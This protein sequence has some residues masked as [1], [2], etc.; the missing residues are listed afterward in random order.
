MIRKYK[1]TVLLLTSALVLQAQ[2]VEGDL[3]KGND[4]YRI[5]Q[6]DLAERHYRAAL[7]L[8]PANTTARYNL[9][10]ALYHQRKFSEAVTVLDENAK[11]PTAGPQV[12]S[13]S[14][15]NKG[16]VYTKQKDLENSIEAYKGALR[17]DPD[18]RQARENLQKALLE[19]KQQQQQQKKNQQERER[20]RSNMSQKEAERQ[21]ERLQQKEQKAQERLQGRGQQGN[22]MPKDW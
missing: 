1:I 7:E 19:L 11:M 5:G 13:A 15:Y 21:L 20:N 4:Y 16:V 18:D 17:I 9:G 8:D 6:F 2:T 10:N 14:Y 12:R 22:S 3:Q